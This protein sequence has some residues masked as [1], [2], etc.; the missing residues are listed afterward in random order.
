MTSLFETENYLTDKKTKVGQEHVNKF[1][2]GECLILSKLLEYEGIKLAFETERPREQILRTIE[3]QITTCLVP[4]EYMD[5]VYHM[6]IGSLWLK[7]TPGHTPAMSLI[8]E[9]ITQKSDVF[10]GRFLSLFENVGHLTQFASGDNAEFQKFLNSQYTMERLSANDSI[11]EEIYLKDVVGQQDYILVKDFHFN[12]CKTLQP[13]ID[14]ILTHKDHKVA[15]FSL[16]E[17][18]YER[19]YL[20]LHE[21]KTRGDTDV[22]AS[23]QDIMV[24]SNMVDSDEFK[25]KRKTSYGKLCAFVELLGKAHTLNKISPA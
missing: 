9:I 24:R 19:E 3:V 10:M 12:L 4:E 8:Q 2:T 15:L 18:F 13:V 23:V 6:M 16:W 22:N 25:M 11:F 1:Y 17:R 7:Y 20:F 14:H 21:G 5:T